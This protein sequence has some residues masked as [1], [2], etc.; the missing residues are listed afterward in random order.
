VKKLAK[1]VMGTLLALSIGVLPMLVVAGPAV[2]AP[3]ATVAATTQKMSQPTLNSTLLG[4]YSKGSRLTLSCYVKGQ[5][6]K[7]YFS[8]WLPNGGWDDL[9]YRVADN[10][11]VADV[12]IDTGS[13]NPVTGPCTTASTTSPAPA[14]VAAKVDAFVA[15]YNN[16]FVD[17]DGAYGAQC[18]DLFNFYNRDVV[19]AGFVRVDYAYQLYAAAP[20]SKY[21]KL[22]ASAT[23][24]KGDVAIWSSSLPGSGNAGHVGI[25]LS[26]P[27]SSTIQVF[28]Q[29]VWLG[30]NKYSPSIIKN[31][32]K[33]Y[34]IGYLRPKV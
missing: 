1:P 22:P 3:M 29:R 23:P 31:E 33:S 28:E 4:W 19:G 7:G 20:S 30:P 27:N 14:G 34:L 32:S 16:K 12:D 10:T 9:W 5:A 15:K 13:N 24:R 2:A 21:E 17:Y 18:V 26:Q 11:Y 8:P 6:V 25:V